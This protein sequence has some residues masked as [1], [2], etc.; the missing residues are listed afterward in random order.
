MY[1]TGYEN[2][3]YNGK[4]KFSAIVHLVA[5][6]DPAEMPLDGTD[7]EGL[8]PSHKG[9]DTTF[10]PGSDCLI[11]STSK[12]KMLNDNLSWDEL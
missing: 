12:V 6:T 5:E 2:V 4:D 10:L 8:F 11:T 3:V 1:I 7:V 9:K